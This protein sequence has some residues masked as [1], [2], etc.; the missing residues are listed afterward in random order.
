MCTT[1]NWYEVMIITIVTVIITII[2]ILI[3][4][5]QIL[6]V[7]NIL[8]KIG[9]FIIIIIIIIIIITKRYWCHC[10]YHVPHSPFP[11]LI[12]RCVL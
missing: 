8:Q 6:N 7:K 2:I 9:P 1:D 12:L 11:L 3:T 5:Y 4:W 10:H